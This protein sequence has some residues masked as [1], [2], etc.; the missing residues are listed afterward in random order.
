MAAFGHEVSSHG[1]AHH[2]EPDECEFAHCSSVAVFLAK[3]AR[4]TD[5]YKVS[6]YPPEF[7]E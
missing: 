4:F 1:K 3:R 6:T 2:A 5:N 7:S